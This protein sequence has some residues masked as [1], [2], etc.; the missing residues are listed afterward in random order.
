MGTASF[1][2]ATSL[3]QHLADYQIPRDPRI[4]DIINSVKLVSHGAESGFEQ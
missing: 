1:K 3:N 2:A 4:M